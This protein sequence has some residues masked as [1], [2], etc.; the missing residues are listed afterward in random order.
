M[1]NSPELLSMSGSPSAE[2]NHGELFVE[3]LGITVS[4]YLP[5]HTDALLDTRGPAA[6][7][8]QVQAAE[9]T[10]CLIQIQSG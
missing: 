3:I 4:R 7:S 6:A 5:H 8:W 10:Q 9:L 2:E 1:S